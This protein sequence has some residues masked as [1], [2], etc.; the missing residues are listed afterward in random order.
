MPLDL[1]QSIPEYEPFLTQLENVHLPQS[2]LYHQQ[3]YNPFPSSHPVIDTPHQTYYAYPDPK[4]IAQNTSD[5]P[6][7]PFDPI[8]V[9]LPPS[10]TTP[11][12]PAPSARPPSAIKSYKPTPTSKSGRTRKP[13]HHALEREIFTEEEIQ[14]ISVNH[15]RTIYLSSLEKRVEGMHKQLSAAHKYPVPSSKL[16]PWCTLKTK[17]S[18]MV[19]AGIQRDLTNMR[20]EYL[21]LERKVH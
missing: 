10:P 4:A 8:Q 20:T 9:P 6:T 12:T 21:E 16:E 14:N 13:W 17:A 7:P 3:L 19:T 11:T 18:R 2:H 5:P 1:S 15:R